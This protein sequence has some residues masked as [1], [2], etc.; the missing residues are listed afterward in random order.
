MTA[1]LTTVSDIIV[2]PSH[3]GAWWIE[4]VVTGLVAEGLA[5]VVLLIFKRKQ[6][7]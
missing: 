3:F 7:A 2:H 1:I 6:Q 5:L 4:G